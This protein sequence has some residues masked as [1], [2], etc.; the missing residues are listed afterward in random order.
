MTAG[1]T[2]G[3]KSVWWSKGKNG[4]DIF[5]WHMNT[6][7][8]KETLGRKLVYSLEQFFGDV[9]SHAKANLRKNGSV[10]SG[11]LEDAIAPVVRHTEPKQYMPMR[12]YA[13]VGIDLDKWKL[14]EGRLKEPIR[15]ASAVEFGYWKSDSHHAYAH[16]Y[17]R[18]AIDVCGGANE[19]REIFREAQRETILET[20]DNGLING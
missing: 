11:A 7:K 15:Y 9:A 19:I 10:K 1:G 3:L 14:S 2:H 13:G 4:D 18:P 16:P 8:V 12:V 5:G 6:L 20:G 17:M